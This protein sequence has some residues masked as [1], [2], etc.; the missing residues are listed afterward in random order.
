MLKGASKIRTDNF[1]M[2]PGI[3]VIKLLV[4]HEEKDYFVY[5][6]S[7]DS[8]FERAGFD[9]RRVYTAAGSWEYYQCA[10]AC[11]S[12]AVFPSVGPVQ[13]I[14]ANLREYGVPRLP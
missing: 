7:A 4:Q 1:Q 5:S 2:D 11:S 9:S 12:R 3:S 10:K 14:L 13:D 8:F 6:C